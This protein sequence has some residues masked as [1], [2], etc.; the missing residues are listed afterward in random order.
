MVCHLHLSNV[1]V[2]QG[3]VNCHPAS[4]GDSK[5]QVYILLILHRMLFNR[6][7]L[8]LLGHRLKPLILLCSLESRVRFGLSQQLLIIYLLY[9]FFLVFTICWGCRRFKSCVE[10]INYYLTDYL[11]SGRNYCLFSSVFQL[12]LDFLLIILYQPCF[13]LLIFVS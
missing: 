8:R 4:P 9:Y 10:L 5:C 13:F 2:K 7:N 1:G 11:G 12:T 3:S 6:Y